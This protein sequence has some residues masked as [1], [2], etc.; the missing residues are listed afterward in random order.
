MVGWR[1]ALVGLGLALGILVTFAAT[2]SVRSMAS[3]R[4]PTAKS[5][6]L[7]QHAIA[8]PIWRMPAFWLLVPSMVA[9]PFTL[10][11]LI[12][13]QGYLASELGLSIST[14]A[15]GFALFALLQIPGSI[16]GGKWTDRF[17]ARSLMPWHLIPAIGGVSVLALFGTSWSVTIYLAL[18]GFSSGWSNVLRSAVIAEMVPPDGIGGARSIAASAMVI[19]TAAGPAIFGFLHSMG[20]GVEEI[21]WASIGALVAA[22]LIAFVGNKVA[23]AARP[24]Q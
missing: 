8:T 16:L 21:L 12:F 11:A 24:P 5:Q 1:Y 17:T 10:T 22:L 18:A 23:S 13:H 15:V 19:S 20:M 9:I 3:F 2:Y 4:K 14:F 6:I 7:G